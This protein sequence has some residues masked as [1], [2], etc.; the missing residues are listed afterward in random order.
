MA[1]YTWERWEV[2]LRLKVGQ[3]EVNKAEKHR[4]KKSKQHRP[5]SKQHMQ[6]KVNSTGQKRKQHRSKSKWQLL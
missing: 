6:K 4:K 3:R 1:Q 5:K 2:G